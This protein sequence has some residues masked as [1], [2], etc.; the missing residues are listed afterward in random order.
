[1]TIT[2]KDNIKEVISKFPE[3]ISVFE[4]YQLTCFSC[5]AASSETIEEIADIHGINLEYFIEELNGVI[6]K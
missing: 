3:T 5:P 4:K 6:K 2:K 1:M